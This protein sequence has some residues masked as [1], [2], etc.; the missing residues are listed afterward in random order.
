MCPIYPYFKLYD[1]VL[2]NITSIKGHVIQIISYTNV[3]DIFYLIKYE[4]QTV[5]YIEEKYLNN[6]RRCPNPP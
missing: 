5:N 2:N 4:N 6:V 1:Y 3:K